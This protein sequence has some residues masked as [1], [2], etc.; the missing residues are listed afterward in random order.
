VLFRSGD[1]F[2][3]IFLRK[4]IY[5]D[6]S[7]VP[8]QKVIDKLIS[9]VKKRYPNVYRVLIKERNEYMARRLAEIKKHYPEDN[10]IAVVGAGHE[11]EIGQLLKSYIKTKK[12]SPS[13]KR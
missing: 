6:L 11:K 7:K 5:I 10:I 9:D 1:L 4:G 12:E 3:G 13:K 2:K 8:P